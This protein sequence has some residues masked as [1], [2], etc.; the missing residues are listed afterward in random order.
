MSI[1]PFI[2]TPQSRANIRANVLRIRK[3]LGYEHE[4]YFPIVEFLEIQYVKFDPEFNL[5]IVEDNELESGVQALAIPEEHTIRVKQSVYEGAVDGVGVHR[6]SLAHEFGHIIMHG[7]QSPII[8][9]RNT[10]YR[11][12]KAFEDPDW[13]AEVFGAELLVPHNLID[14][15][16]AEEIAESCQVSLKCANCQ[17]KNFNR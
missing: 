6:L 7:A 4:L 11:K 5:I 3:S 2:A 9:Q 1:F 12:I 14:G 15:M 16:T 13:Q 8:L 10:A 17:L